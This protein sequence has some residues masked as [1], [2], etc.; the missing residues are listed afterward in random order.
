MQYTSTNTKVAHIIN[1]KV[2]ATAPGKAV[3]IAKD[4]VTNRQTMLNL[5]VFGEED[6]GY[7]KYDKPVTD[8]FVL[9]G[10]LTNK[11][12]YFLSTDE[13]EIGSTGDEMKFVGGNYTLSMYPS[14]SVTLRY[15]LDAFFPN[16]TESFISN[17]TEARIP[18]WQRIKR[19]TVSANFFTRMQS[20]SV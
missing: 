12:Y 7:V 3:I 6:E 20:I 10:Y 18:R 19:T 4:P 16:D 5:T 8:N 9:T 11:A 17:S 2:V 1:N 13:R 15:R 14:E